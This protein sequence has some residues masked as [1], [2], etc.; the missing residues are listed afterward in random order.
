[1][2]C[3]NGNNCH[4]ASGKTACDD[5]ENNCTGEFSRV[6]LSESGDNVKCSCCE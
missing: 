4:E 1:M 6:I 2:Y 5:L 3:S